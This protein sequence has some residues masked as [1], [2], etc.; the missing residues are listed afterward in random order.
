[1]S[2]TRN[3]IAV[4]RN[5]NEPSLFSRIVTPLNVTTLALLV[6]ILPEINHQVSDLLFFLLRPATVALAVTGVAAA[7]SVIATI[8]GI[9]IGLRPGFVAFGPV[10]IR[11]GG[12]IGWGLGINRSWR[13]YI[14]SVVLVPAQG[15]FGM[16]QM[17]I[18]AG[19]GLISSLALLVWLFVLARSYG[20]PAVE[21]PGLSTQMEVLLVSAPLGAAIV[22]VAELLTGGTVLSA[23]LRGSQD[24]ANRMLATMTIA[25]RMAT[26]E[27]PEK[28][29]P[30]LLEGAISVPDTTA[31]HLM[32]LSFAYL[33]AVDHG[34]L[35]SANRHLQAFERWLQES[36]PNVRPY[37]ISSLAGYASLYHERAWL[38]AAHWKDLERAS[39]YLNRSAGFDAAMPIDLRVKA[40]ILALEGDQE[41]AEK[42][43]RTGLEVLDTLPVM[44]R[45]RAPFE[46]D[47][48]NRVLERNRT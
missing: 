33:A 1:M 34:D 10:Q 15:R 31:D 23:L 37:V 46:R 8:V 39:E 21:D 19:V 13:H 42:L 45:W 38:S 22:T 26:G 28:W 11:L 9:M 6:L 7:V 20:W 27:P 25:S 18:A 43:A 17:I 3:G 48:L 40:E 44:E 32:G 41:S 12:E 30:E 36:N 14:G 24:Q 4:P 47:L 16:Y 5:R 29:E 2:E 35:D